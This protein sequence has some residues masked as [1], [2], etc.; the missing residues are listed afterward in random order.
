MTRSSVL[1]LVA[2]AFIVA[3]CGGSATPTSPA[4]PGETPG[5]RQQITLAPG[6]SAT[7][8]STT[9]AIRFDGVTTDSRC[10]ADALCIQLGYAEAV[11]AVTEGGQPASALA[12]RTLGDASVARVG[13]YRLE[14]ET[15]QPYPYSRRQIPADEYRATLLVERP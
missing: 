3:G 10:P 2:F 8:P 5:L 9:L 11:F 1:P 14:L 13:R 4:A 12:L 15:L 7:V 6:Q